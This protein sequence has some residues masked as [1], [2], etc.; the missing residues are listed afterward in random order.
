MPANEDK[1]LDDI[2]RLLVL[3]LMKLG[4]TS[5]EISLALQVDSSL[6]RRMM[7]GRKVKRIVEKANG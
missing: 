5:E 6:V 3:L 7:P 2:K 4:S 1:Q